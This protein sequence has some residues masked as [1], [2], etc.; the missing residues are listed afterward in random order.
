MKAAIAVIAALCAAGAFWFVPLTVQ[1]AGSPCAAV[2]YRSMQ[3]NTGD[4]PPSRLAAGM[5][6]TVGAPLLAAA[7]HERHRQVP[8]E[9]SCAALWWRSL[10]SPELLEGPL[11]RRN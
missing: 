10:G 3:V 2:V 1:H 8:A 11:V 4:L 7:M 9:V 5:L 6:A